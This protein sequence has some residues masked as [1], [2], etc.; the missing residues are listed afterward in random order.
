MDRGV[1]GGCASGGV[2]L[3]AD[4]ESCCVVIVRMQRQAVKLS[5]RRGAPTSTLLPY[6][7][8]FR[9]ERGGTQAGDGD[10]VGGV[11]IALEMRGDGERDRAVLVDAG[12]RKSSRLNSSHEWIAYGVVG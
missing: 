5:Y 12:D 8:L 2:R 10:G 4:R 9:S 6:T 11:G 3:D 1:G 7:T